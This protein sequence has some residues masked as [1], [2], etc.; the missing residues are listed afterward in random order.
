MWTAKQNV[1][2]LFKEGANVCWIWNNDRMEPPSKH[3]LQT[4]TMM[5]KL[6]VIMIFISTQSACSCPKST[7]K[8]WQYDVEENQK[9]I[10]TTVTYPCWIVL[11]KYAEISRE[12]HSPWRGKTRGDTVTS[13]FCEIL[14]QI[15]ELIFGNGEN[16]DKEQH[17][18]G[19]HL[20]DGQIVTAAPHAKCNNNNNN[21]NNNKWWLSQPWVSR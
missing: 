10:Q 5:M 19:G 14:P 16:D 11:R 1:Y 12:G 9:Q 21:N 3:V 13:T 17:E 15:K 20:I 4:L 18:A 8:Q 7:T 6:Q 2:G